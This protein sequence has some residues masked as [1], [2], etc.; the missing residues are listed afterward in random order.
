MRRRN[1]TCCREEET[2]SGSRKCTYLFFLYLVVIVLL[3]QYIHD[4]IQKYLFEP[5]NEEAESITFKLRTDDDGGPSL[6]ICNS[7]LK[8]GREL[9]MAV[10]EVEDNSIKHSYRCT[11]QDNAQ[12]TPSRCQEAKV[13]VCQE[14]Q[15]QK[16]LA[17]ETPCTQRPKKRTEIQICQNPPSSPAAQKQ[18]KELVSC[19]CKLDQFD[20]YAECMK[21]L[22]DM[23]AEAKA[24]EKCD[25]PKVPKKN[26]AENLFRKLKMPNCKKKQCAQEKS[27]VPTCDC[28]HRNRERLDCR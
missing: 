12:A 4:K 11:N 22:K 8:K 24:E 17:E 28:K 10:D 2:G 20:P 19:S 15:V 18:T 21:A 14:S 6:E 13:Q 5:D 1:N 16:C 25:V 7:K 3:T 26:M 23:L 9:V 27:A